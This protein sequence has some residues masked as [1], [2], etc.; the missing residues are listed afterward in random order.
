MPADFV[1]GLGGDGDG[2]AF[3]AVYRRKAPFV[4]GGA[5]Q[6]E[7]PGVKNL[8]PGILIP[9]AETENCGFFGDKL[10][11]PVGQRIN[12]TGLF[13]KLQ[14]ITFILKGKHGETS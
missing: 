9:G 5:Q 13:I 4:G 10:L 7:V 2:Q 6:R 12:G 11:P 14:R 8:L 1:T 3:P